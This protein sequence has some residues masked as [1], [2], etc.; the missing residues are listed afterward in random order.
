MSTDSTNG[1]N[2][3]PLGPRERQRYARMSFK[4]GIHPECI[5]AD[6]QWCKRYG[7]R[8]CLTCRT[9]SVC[10]GTLM[11]THIVLAVHPRVTHKGV[12]YAC[13][14]CSARINRGQIVY[15]RND[16][17]TA[18]HHPVFPPLCAVQRCGHRAWDGQKI[19]VEGKSHLV[20]D[21]HKRQHKRWLTMGRD[22]NMPHLVPGL[23]GLEIT[24]RR[25]P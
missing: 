12:E 8:K 6:R 23:D 15:E 5:N 14:Q 17:A 19:E 18:G 10:G 4:D 9:C 25:K 20:C 21:L 7:V 16:T 1:S 2:D 13:I 24:I 3:D 11:L 22:P